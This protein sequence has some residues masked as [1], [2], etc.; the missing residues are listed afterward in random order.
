MR[1]KRNRKIGVSYFRLPFIDSWLTRPEVTEA[2]NRTRTLSK[3]KDHPILFDAYGISI[4][5]RS[6]V[7]IWCVDRSPGFVQEWSTPVI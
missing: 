4:C 7:G 1:W 6:L 5:E 2:R 3:S